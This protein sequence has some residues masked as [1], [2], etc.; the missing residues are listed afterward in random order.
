MDIK[1][2]VFLISQVLIG[3]AFCFDLLSFQLK[4]R[5]QILICFIVAS[6]LIATHFFLLEQVTAACLILVSTTRFL[7][8]YFTTAKRWMVFFLLITTVVF[9][10][11]FAGK[12]SILAY[13]ASLIGT[14][15]SFQDKDKALRLCM[16]MGTTLWIIHN[17]FAGSP[18]AVALEIFFLGSNLWGYY[19]FYIRKIPT[20]A[21]TGQEL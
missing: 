18:A 21:E 10:F 14:W 16:M 17:I 9:Y 15:G 3:I 19:R 6:T 20:S 11:T 12:L 1:V 13:A 7:A 4:E 8:S 5:K 2:S